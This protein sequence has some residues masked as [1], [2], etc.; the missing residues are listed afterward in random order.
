MTTGPRKKK[1]P[2]DIKSFSHE[3]DPRGVHSHL[4]WRPHSSD[5]LEAVLNALRARFNTAKEEVN[6]ELAVFAGNLVEILEKNGDASPDWKEKIEDL[7]ILAR[8]CAIMST[9]EFRQQGENIVQELDDRRQELP[10]GLLKQLHTRMLFILTR[11]TRLLQFQKESG[12]D[13]DDHNS[14]FSA[15]A[16]VDSSVEGSHNLIASRK[17]K[18]VANSLKDKKARSP[19][20]FYSQELRGYGWK[21]KEVF[22][23]S[24]R[25]LPEDGE[26]SKKLLLEETISNTRKD[27]AVPN[28]VNSL[29]ASRL[30]SWKKFTASSEHKAGRQGLSEAIQTNIQDFQLDLNKKNGALK[31]H[32]DRDGG[33]A[34]VQ[35]APLKESSRT[36][37]KPQQKVAWGYVG[38]LGGSVEDIKLVCRICEEVVP[39]LHLEEHS[40]VCAFADRCDYKALGIDERLNRLAETLEKM[41]E[42]YT[43]KSIQAGTGGSPDTVKQLNAR[44]GGEGSEGVSPRVSELPRRDSEDMLEDLHEMDAASLEDLRGF[45]ANYG[46]TRFGP[47]SDLGL[48]ASSTGSGTPC[49]PLVTPRTSQIDLLLAERCSAAEMEDLG[50]IDELVDIARC[51]ANTNVADGGAMEYLVSCMQ[52]LQDVLQHRKVEAL[53]V[54]TFGKRIDKLLREKYVQV[55]EMLE[56]NSVE[57]TSIF[58]EEDGTFE[59]DALHS[60]RSTPLH[61]GYKDRTSIDDFEIIKPISRGAF[62]RVFLARKRTTGDLFAIKVLRKADMIRKNAVESVQAERNILI[63][64]R[65]PFVVRFFYSFTCRDNLYLVM[66]YLNG[67]DLYSMLRSLGC[68]EEDMARVYIAELVLALEYLHSLGVVHRDLK[69]DNILIAHDGHIKLTDFG[70][71]KVGLINSTDDLSCPAVSSGNMLMDESVNIHQNIEYSMKRERRQQRSAVGTPDYLAPEILLGTAHGCT[72]DWWSV[73]VILFEFL[74]GIPPFNAEHPQIIFD[75]ILNR[76]IPWPQVPEDLSYE[77]QDLIDRLL[78]EDPDQRLGAKGATEVKAHLFFKDIKWETLARQKA[79]FIPSPDTAHDTS[80]FTSRH[81]WSSTDGRVD[82]EQEFPDSSDYASSSS[83]RTSLSSRPEEGD[84]YKDLADFESTPAAKYTF[85]N[86]SFKNLSQLASINYDLLLQSSKDSSKA[87]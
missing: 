17:G 56:Q 19:P 49:S 2:N 7:L 34:I 60:L 16:K 11:C 33:T 72:A 35:E 43:P 84:E 77:A 26:R 75:N 37:L 83:S 57:S 20:R 9:V 73:G 13:E 70:L 64:A 14:S 58:P 71:S 8:Q 6:T 36:A 78:A 51:V 74:V 80:Y 52:D 69:P 29:I 48:T 28:H 32:L 22:I 15:H 24:Q 38:E 50:Q 23:P 27:S 47:R 87:P 82:A 31:S 10:V 66:E 61:S 3:L 39:T 1:L 76:K 40:R 53:T 45:S 54:D 86:F 79:A 4:Y 67:G 18:A 21:N 55:C 59:E 30:A 65:N 41:L 81:R 42:S 12:L 68:L 63:S 46:K 5:D 25:I 62:G 85:N 44:K